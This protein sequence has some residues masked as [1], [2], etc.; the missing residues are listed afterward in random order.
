MKR[1]S[2]ERLFL[3]VGLDHSELQCFGKLHGSKTISKTLHLL[4]PGSP[5][6]SHP[7]RHLPHTPPPF[8]PGGARSHPSGL[9]PVA[10]GTSDRAAWD[11][12]HFPALII[13]ACSA[14]TAPRRQ[15]QPPPPPPPSACIL[16]V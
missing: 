13:P 2:E 15:G 12:A 1:L 4:F 3:S 7:H 14:G 8:T 16:S 5:R 9:S 6:A 10:L 11:S